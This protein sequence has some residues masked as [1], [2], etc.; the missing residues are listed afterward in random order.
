MLGAVVYFFLADTLGLNYVWASLAAVSAVGFL[1]WLTD[2]AIFFRLHGNL[3]GGVIATA[4]L[5]MVFQN[6]TWFVFGPRSQQVSPFLTGV[7]SIFGATVAKE[8]LLIVLASFIVITLLGWLIR[9]TKLGRAMRAVQQDSEAALTL[10]INVN[11]ICA[12]TFGIASGLAALA[13]VLIAPLYHVHPTMGV[14]PLLVAF[15]VI[16]LGGM[17]SVMGAL[18][19]SF[20]IGFQQSITATFW[21]PEFATGVSFGLALMMLLFLPRG[22][23]GHD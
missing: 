3:M 8:R 11:R 14:G 10:G 12:F 5:C 13:G 17:G 21:G 22:L 23:M 2:K 4:G 6:A 16:V 15:I 18:I 19:A 1:G 7:V 20:I 9:Y